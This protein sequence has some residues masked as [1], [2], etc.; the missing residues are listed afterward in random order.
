M[1]QIHYFNP[2]A[3]LA[4]ANGHVSY[5]PPAQLQAFEADLACLPMVYAHIGDLVAVQHKL[6]Q[7]LIDS[8]ES[9]GLQVPVFVE[10]DELPRIC[11][12]G[13][14]RLQPWAN[15]PNLARIFLPYNHHEKKG[16]ANLSIPQWDSRL[17]DLSSRSSAADIWGKLANEGFAKTEDIPDSCADIAMVQAA[18]A[19]KGRSV[20]K[21]SHTSSG[22]GI[23]FADNAIAE[24]DLTRIKNQIAHGCIVDKWRD[25]IADF[26]MHFAPSGSGAEYLGWTQM[27]NTPTGRYLGSELHTDD[28]LQAGGH[29]LHI[30]ELL[31][32]LQEFYTKHLP[33]SIY[34]Q[35]HNGPV[36]IDMLMYRSE[37]GRPAIHPC[38]EINARHTMGYVCL[39]LKKLLHPDAKGIFHILHLPQGVEHE[40][41][42]KQAE[43]QL[44]TEGG[45]IRRGSLPLTDYTHGARF[46]AML[47]VL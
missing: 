18:V 38:V 15:S 10:K 23:F 13:Q 8:W 44:V 12:S 42:R 40:C 6:P 43:S 33:E 39:S 25:K 47:T 27:H 9:A 16:I 41:I 19:R 34:M 4:V 26:S 17:Q 36:G 30:R 20:I 1:K 7:H 29:T 21:L 46:A 45:K 37:D 24:A 14:Y 11:A 28:I 5:Q 3:E 22:R 2:T 32:P 35:M 31:A